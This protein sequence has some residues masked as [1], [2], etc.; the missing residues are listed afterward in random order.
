VK[1]R[2]LAAS[3]AP[4]ISSK[5][6]T[7]SWLRPECDGCPVPTR[8]PTDA[9]IKL[10]PRCHQDSAASEVITELLLWCWHTLPQ[11]KLE[12]CN[13]L[14]WWTSMPSKVINIWGWVPTP[15]NLRYQW[16]FQQLGRWLYELS[17]SR[18]GR[19]LRPRWSCSPIYSRCWDWRHGTQARQ[20]NLYE[21]WG[22][23]IL[24]RS[25]RA[26]LPPCHGCWFHC[27]QHPGRSEITRRN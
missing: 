15:S 20:I 13:L 5:L 11:V 19:C 2:L 18:A 17:I 6:F 26:E 7:G 25:A 16:L 21:R 27:S 4:S 10:Y 14:K 3:S 12:A 9:G 23:P 1:K 8:L 24:G 22:D